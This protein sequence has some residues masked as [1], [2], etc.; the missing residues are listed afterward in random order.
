MRGTRL[1]AVL[2]ACASCSGNPGSRPAAAVEIVSDAPDPITGHLFRL[3]LGFT[4]RRGWHVYWRNPGDAGTPV[5]VSWKLPAG[6]RAGPL[7]WPAPDRFVQPGQI[8]AYGYT[9]ETALWCEVLPPVAPASGRLQGE[10][11]I[12]WMECD[13]HTC[14]PRTAVVP[15]DLPTGRAARNA[16]RLDRW[17]ARL[18]VAADAPASPA[19]ATVT[20]GVRHGNRT[21]WKV[22]LKW[23]GPSRPVRWVAPEADGAAVENV[24]VRMPV[25]GRTELAFTLVTALGRRGPPPTDALLIVHDGSDGRTA[26]MTV[27]LSARKGAR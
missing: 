22:A 24:E 10:A 26:A 13:E 16:E 18:P 20:R 19:V 7:H 2:L 11:E 17:S 1:A 3:G 27:R 6:W 5:V 23:K 21:A 4:I 12:R 25:P 14:V 15:F 9:R 8:V